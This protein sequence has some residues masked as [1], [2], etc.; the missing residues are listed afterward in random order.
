MDQKR[1]SSSAGTDV[2]VVYI[3]CCASIYFDFLNFYQA[4]FWYM[5]TLGMISWFLQYHNAQEQR[6]AS[7]NTDEN[8]PR[9]VALVRP[10]ARP[11]DRLGTSEPH[12]VTRVTSSVVSS[13]SQVAQGSGRARF[14]HSLNSDLTP[15]RRPHSQSIAQGEEAPQSV[16]FRDP[17]N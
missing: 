7:T 3:V 13:T 4:F 12:R 15:L 5:V 8:R 1:S 9:P 10:L 14:R 2:S 6:D 11:Y 16:N 17:R